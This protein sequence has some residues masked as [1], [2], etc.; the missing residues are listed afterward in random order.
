MLKSLG[1][2]AFW[3]RLGPRVCVCM[4]RGRMD[5]GLAARIRPLVFAGFA[6]WIDRPGRG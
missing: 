3:L 1:E 2:V 5:D 4:R 6:C